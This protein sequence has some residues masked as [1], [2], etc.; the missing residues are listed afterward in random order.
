MDEKD[1]FLDLSK[2]SLLNEIGQGAFS[3][4][5]RVKEN[6]TGE[7]F[8]AKIL[9]KE[10]N[11]EIINSEEMILLLREINL[12][13]SMNHPSILKYIGF[14]PNDFQQ[15]QYPTIITKY[16]PKGSLRDIIKKELSGLAPKEWDST[17]KLINIFGIASGLAYLHLHEIFHRDMKP[18][19]I[20]IY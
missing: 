6:S 16:A 17:K 20:L 15:N 2:Y 12:M 14:S 10:I 4:V 3:N 1:K 9:K 13:S 18:E 8:A 19:N 7:I 5:H 11:D